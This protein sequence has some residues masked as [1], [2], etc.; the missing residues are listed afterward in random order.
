[1]GSPQIPLLGTVPTTVP[2]AIG[3]IAVALYVAYRMLLPKPIPGIPYNKEAAENLFGD[4]PFIMKEMAESGGGEF[5]KYVC[6]Q[7]SRHNTPIFQVWARPFGK[8]WVLL[9]DFRESQDI[10]MRRT[11]EFDRSTFFGDLFAGTIPN[12]HIRKQS[13]DPKFKSNRA[14]VKDLMTPAF[15]HDVSSLTRVFYSSALY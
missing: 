11:K 2:L 8:P 12:H 6:S 4:V 1:M 13:T 7:P 3:I 14:L 15:L 9:T 5:W 10:M